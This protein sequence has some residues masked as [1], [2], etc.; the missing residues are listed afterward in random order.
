[1]KYNKGV[2]K[3]IIYDFIYGKGLTGKTHD[4]EFY[5]NFKKESNNQGQ[6]YDKTECSERLERKG[7]FVRQ[8]YLFS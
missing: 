6:S 7:N 2:P 5:S 3:I 8:K 1:M 4:R